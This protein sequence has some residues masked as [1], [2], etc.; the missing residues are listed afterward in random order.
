MAYKQ[1]GRAGLEPAASSFARM[2]SSRLSY[3][4]ILFIRHF[5]G[6]SLGRDGPS[7]HVFKTGGA[8][9]VVS[10]LVLFKYRF[11]RMPHHSES[12]EVDQHIICP[13]LQLPSTEETIPT[14]RFRPSL[15]PLIPSRPI[16]YRVDIWRWG[17]F[18]RHAFIM[19]QPLAWRCRALRAFTS[20]M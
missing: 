6:D 9:G 5:V 19:P 11:R 10:V 13:F 20:S 1:R 8:H 12:I 7:L 18:V 4:R 17:Q 3:L 15:R 2:R 14:R 16:P